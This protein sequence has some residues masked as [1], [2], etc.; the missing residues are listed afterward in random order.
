MIT[1]ICNICGCK[2]TCDLFYH[3]TE[4]ILNEFIGFSHLQL[5]STVVVRSAATGQ[6]WRRH[7]E[8]LLWCITLHLVWCWILQFF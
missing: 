1:D 3:R 6:D 4:L 7:T 8:V 5:C 2:F